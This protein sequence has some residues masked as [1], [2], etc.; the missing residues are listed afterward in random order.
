VEPGVTRVDEGEVS[1]S[2]ARR[3]FRRAARASSRVGVFALSIVST[4]ILQ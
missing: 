1:A 3:D 2:L 4:L